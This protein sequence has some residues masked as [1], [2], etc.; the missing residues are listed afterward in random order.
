MLPKRLKRKVADAVSL[1]ADPQ[2]VPSKK[3][4]MRVESPKWKME[5][6]SWDAPDGKS[7]L[8]R[9]TTDQL[10]SIAELSVLPHY[11]QTSDGV[12]KTPLSR[13][14]PLLRS[15]VHWNGYRNQE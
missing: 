10:M 9:G 14:R 5:P 6:R 7:P 3:Y 15:Q 8:T 4:K 13:G 2:F 12:D 1:E 11:V